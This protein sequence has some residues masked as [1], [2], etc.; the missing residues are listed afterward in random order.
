MYFTYVALVGMFINN[1]IWPSFTLPFTCMVPEEPKSTGE[2]SY[3]LVTISF[4]M[5]VAH[6][7]DQEQMLRVLLHSWGF[8]LETVLFWPLREI[9]A[10]HELVHA[11]VGLADGRERREQPEGGRMYGIGEGEEGPRA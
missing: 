1:Q 8:I 2:S 7:R 4:L 5:I 6:S 10:P 3:A 9:L 11:A